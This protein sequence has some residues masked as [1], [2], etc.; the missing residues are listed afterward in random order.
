MSVV[1]SQFRSAMRLFPFV[2]WPSP[3]ALCHLLFVIWPSPSALRHLAFAICPLSSGLH[4]LPFVICPLSSGLRH[5]P[6]VIWPSPSALCHLAFAICP[7]SS[8]LCHLPF[9]ICPLSS[10]IPCLEND[11]LEGDLLGNVPGL[12]KNTVLPGIM[13]GHLREP[14][15]QQTKT[16]SARGP[17]PFAPGDFHP[18]EAKDVDPLP[19]TSFDSPASAAST[20]DRPAVTVPTSSPIAP[21]P[22]TPDRTR[23]SWSRP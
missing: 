14:D 17:R 1:G 20:A 22:L 19:A 21:A 11:R 12:R 2:I 7:S 13:N 6:F 18:E 23:R 15:T 4:H 5:L 10:A 3:S 16:L 9:A 8:A